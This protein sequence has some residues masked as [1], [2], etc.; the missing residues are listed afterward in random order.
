[1][2]VCVH[3]CECVWI[4][5]I[6]VVSLKVKLECCKYVPRS[7]FSSQA[8][9]GGGLQKIFGVSKEGSDSEICSL[10]LETKEPYI[11]ISL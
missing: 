9:G 11:L 7:C 4:F 8:A 6:F 3:V 10:Y 1:M 5:R 2:C